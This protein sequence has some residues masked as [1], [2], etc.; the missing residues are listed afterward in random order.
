LDNVEVVFGEYADPK[1]PDGQIDLAITALTYHHIDSRVEYFSNLQRDLSA[2]GRVAHLDDRDDLP[3]PIRW[4][5]TKGHWSNVDAMNDE[6]DRAG[7]ARTASFDFLPLQSF[8]IFEPRTAVA[9][10]VPVPEAVGP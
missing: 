5:P 1:L 8:Q 6:M 7:Y 4:L 9:Q 2:T 3:R 10:S